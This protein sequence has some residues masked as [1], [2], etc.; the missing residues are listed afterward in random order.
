MLADRAAVIWT[1]LV[2][3][4]VITGCSTNSGVELLGQS[5]P[6]IESNEVKLVEI[7]PATAEPIA[8][9]TSNFSYGVRETDESKRSYAIERALVQ[10]AKLGA[11]ILV[12]DKVEYQQTTSGGVTGGLYDG[13]TVSSIPAQR[14][15]VVHA[16]AYYLE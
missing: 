15:P 6:A 16:K 1:L 12:I 3:L 4:L 9:I 7:A 13:Q 2:G 10:A 5:R 8:K 11:N 14:T